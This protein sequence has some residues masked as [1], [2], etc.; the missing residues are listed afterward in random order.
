MLRFRMNKLRNP[1]G[2]YLSAESLQGKVSALMTPGCPAYL[3]KNVVSM[4]F[5]L[6]KISLYDK[7][8]NQLAQTIEITPFEKKF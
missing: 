6:R 1:A 5:L 8:G 4:D 2:L 7:I 3:R